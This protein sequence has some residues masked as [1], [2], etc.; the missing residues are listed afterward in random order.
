MKSVNKRPLWYVVNRLVLSYIIGLSIGR[1]QEG[2]N[3]WFKE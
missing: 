1:A 3:R 2:P